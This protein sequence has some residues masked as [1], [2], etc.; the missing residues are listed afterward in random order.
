MRIVTTLLL[1]FAACGD[2][3]Q[4]TTSGACDTRTVNSVCIEYAGP[5][6]VVDTYKNSC[7]P[8]T[9]S[10]A[11]CPTASRVGGC[12]MTDAGLMLTYTQQYYGST[13]TSSSAMGACTKGTFVP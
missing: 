9:W 10:D 13:F 7:A 5:R 6:S 2:S 4:T 3:A 8:G 1:L 12:K 11:T